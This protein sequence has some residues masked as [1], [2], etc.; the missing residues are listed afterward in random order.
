MNL[1]FLPLAG[2]LAMAGPAFGISVNLTDFSFAEPR[3]V[4]VTDP[5]S[6]GAFEA[7]LAGQFFGTLTGSDGLGATTSSVARRS[8]ES[9]V[10][11]SS[12][13]TAYCAELTESFQ[14]GVSTQLSLYLLLTD[15][16]VHDGIPVAPDEMD[17]ATSRRR[18]PDTWGRWRRAGDGIQVAWNKTPQQW[19]ALRGDPV[20]KVRPSDPLQGRF[21]GGDSYTSGDNASYALYGVT[22]A[23]GQR[24]ETDSRSGSGTGTLTDAMGGTSV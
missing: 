15:G 4:V 22:F 19:E 5:S 7:A 3:T 1:K 18:E 2:A 17:I 6:A 14:L 24:F 12:P 23:A 9:V 16:T 21:S 13:F 11:S 10:A 8:V 20:V